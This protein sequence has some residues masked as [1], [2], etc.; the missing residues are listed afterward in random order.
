MINEG[1]FD[2][3]MEKL[4]KVEIG[5]EEPYRYIFDIPDENWSLSGYV[6][7]K[8]KAKE[9]CEGIISEQNLI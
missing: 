1:S 8:I 6:A 5:I 4:H 9:M 7:S 3:Y 2:L